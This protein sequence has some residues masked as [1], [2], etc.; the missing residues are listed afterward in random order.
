[1]GS[2]GS[3][4]GATPRLSSAGAPA[5]RCTRVTRA[6]LSHG[7]QRLLRPG[8]NPRP[9][10]WRVD[11]HPPSHRGSSFKFVFNRCQGCH[12]LLRECGCPGGAS[13]KAPARQGR[14]HK[15]RGFDPG[16]GRSPGEGSG[17][18]LQCSCL[19]NPTD[20]GAGQATVHGVLES[21]TR[22]KRLGSNIT[23]T[24]GV[25]YR[26]P[27]FLKV[28]LLPLSRFSHVRLFETP[29]Y[30]KNKHLKDSQR[31]KTSD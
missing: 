20:R 23:E 29:C 19:E 13:G 14:R 21:R 11:V 31:E 30:N 24:T 3:A 9:R 5:L 16:S 10:H 18:P 22:L 6:Q 17:N 25:P 26:D 2:P 15:R 4:A 12:L 1:M 28:M 27:Q 7:A 8:P